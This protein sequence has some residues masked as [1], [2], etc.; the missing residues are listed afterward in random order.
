MPFFLPSQQRHSTEG[1]SD[2]AAARALLLLC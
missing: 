1:L 2:E